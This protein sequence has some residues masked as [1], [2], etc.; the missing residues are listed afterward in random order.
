MNRAKSP[1]I[2]L[3]MLLVFTAVWAAHAAD[4]YSGAASQT[5]SG[6]YAVTFHVTVAPSVPDGSTI[7]CKARIAPMLLVLENPGSAAVPV[8][9][10]Q[11]IATVIGSTADC[12]VQLPF[13][14]AVADAANGAALSCQIE[15][16]TSA[17]PIFLRSQQ[18]IAVPY[19]Q[20]GATANLL[21]DL[22]F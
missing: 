21:L 3:L 14:F 2:L 10:A 6:A 20:A 16:Y 11:G 4:T 8:E 9:S 12:M 18:D 15:A 17:G 19:P 22:S 1:Q 13:A 7:A 5:A